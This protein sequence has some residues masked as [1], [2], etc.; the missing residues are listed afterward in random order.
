MRRLW[1]RL[2]A[3]RLGSLR[4]HS[5]MGLRCL[6]SRPVRILWSPLPGWWV[7]GVHRTHHS[8]AGRVRQVCSS[9]VLGRRRIA[10]LA[11][12]DAK[13]LRHETGR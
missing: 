13:S 7:V 12:P 9:T 11:S 6:G 5:L 4:G 8:T 3:P 10:R 1:N 2:A